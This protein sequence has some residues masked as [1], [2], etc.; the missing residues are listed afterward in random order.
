MSIISNGSSNKSAILSD[1]RKYRYLLWRLCES[2][3]FDYNNPKS[4]MFIGL[5]PSTADENL[6]DPTIRRL[7][8]FSTR[9]GCCEM[10]MT[11][12]FAFRATK[13]ADMF[14]EADPVGKFNDFYI[15]QVA[16][17][18][19][20]IVACWGSFNGIDERIKAVTA[21]VPADKL[22]CFGVNADGNPKHPLYLPKTA[23]L[24]KYPLLNEA[25]QS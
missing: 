17:K 11:N 10:T 20:I 2:D 5:N 13:P 19:D 22:F 23:Q 18:A 15:T 7:I 9:F 12:L 21:I 4:I 25:L 3:M 24:I 1:D 6:D 14:K 16:K 8:D